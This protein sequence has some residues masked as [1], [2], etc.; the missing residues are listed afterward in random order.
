MPF[1]VKLAVDHL[2]LLL[3]GCICFSAFYINLPVSVFYFATVVLA[4]HFFR[5]CDNKLEWFK[6][7]KS[8]LICAGAFSVFVIASLIWCE[9]FFTCLRPTVKLA[10]YVMAAT[11]F[12]LWLDFAR[13]SFCNRLGKDTTA[14]VYLFTGIL[15]FVAVDTLLGFR[16]IKGIYQFFDA[17]RIPR[18]LYITYY[19]W[20]FAAAVLICPV[21][22][23]TYIRGKRLLAGFMLLTA[24]W[25]LLHVDND[26]AV[27]GCI[28][29]TFVFLFGYLHFGFVSKFMKM[30]LLILAI[31]PLFYNNLVSPKWL[32][33][34]VPLFRNTSYLHRIIIMYSCSDTVKS[35]FPFGN[36]VGAIMK[37]RPQ[38]AEKFCRDWLKMYS[39]SIWNVNGKNISSH[40]FYGRAYAKGKNAC[41]L[42]ISRRP[43][44]VEK[45][46]D[47][48]VF[49]YNRLGMEIETLFR[50]PVQPHNIIFELWTSLGVVGIA[51]YLVL[52]FWAINWIGNIRHRAFRACCL[53]SLMAATSISLVNYSLVNSWWVYSFSVLGGIIYIMSKLD[54]VYPVSVISKA[55]K[56]L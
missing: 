2:Q 56:P 3:V 30:G 12:F 16:L 17:K 34:N 22:V 48:T 53:S 44:F 8:I 7:Q 11:M 54:R 39:A 47:R 46:G 45:N 50:V 18:T 42:I 29:S 31:I 6:K 13:P 40:L 49:T 35:C 20:S 23:L 10:A 27:L 1:I 28:V 51:F 9:D 21:V 37:E 4:V 55:S 38:P 43:M 25:A 36:G 26:S 33:E 19:R 24:C 32:H 41:Y 14:F 15:V 52:Y 5:N